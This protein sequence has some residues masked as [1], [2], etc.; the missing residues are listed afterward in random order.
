MP[1]PLVS[2]KSSAARPSAVAPK[3]V[4]VTADATLRE[5]DAFVQ[6]TWLTS[7]KA[8]GARQT[9]LGTTPL[10]ASASPGDDIKALEWDLTSVF[11]E[12]K[13]CGRLVESL[14]SS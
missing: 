12:T 13:L 3:G 2:V 8:V 9:S 6:A 7:A 4:L 1:C 11:T 14:E 10:V 5:T